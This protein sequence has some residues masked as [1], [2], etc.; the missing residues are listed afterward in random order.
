M[1]N[2]YGVNKD[3]EKWEILRQEIFDFSVYVN[4]II[5]KQ[6]R[7]MIIRLERNKWGQKFIQIMQVCPLKIVL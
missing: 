1:S 3:K 5:G 6:D 2:A 4:A 7:K